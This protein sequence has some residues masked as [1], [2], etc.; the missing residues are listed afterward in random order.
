MTELN[1]H[2]W[3]LA[4]ER[5]EDIS[6]VPEETRRRYRELEQLLAGLPGP[7]PHQGWQRRVLDAVDA[8]HAP[9]VGA[10]CESAPPP[11]VRSWPRAS[12]PPSVPRHWAPH[13]AATPV[14]RRLRIATRATTALTLVLAVSLVDHGGDGASQADMA[15]PLVMVRRGNKL[16][17]GG[18][19]SIGDT[20]V[21]HMKAD[22]PS[23]LRVYGDAGELLARCAEPE[24]CARDRSQRHHWFQLELVLHAPG[25]VR[26]VMF[27]GRAPDTVDNIEADLEAAQRANV[28]VHQISIIR[29]Q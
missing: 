21:V 7:I 2:E 8:T 3:L 29:V 17:R 11:S 23:E 19:A 9:A 27:A 5:G 4:R 1:D 15:A 16:H 28:A 13:L 22:R 18:S 6:H 26:T 10:R 20:L 12:W 25:D 24:P 14:R